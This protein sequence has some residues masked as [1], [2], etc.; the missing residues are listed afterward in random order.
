MSF[1]GHLALFGDLWLSK[2]QEIGGGM[3]VPLRN[4]ITCL[5]IYRANNCPVLNAIGVGEGG[6]RET[7]LLCFIA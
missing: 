7:L 4:A 2:L 3:C 6:S 5:L 1:R